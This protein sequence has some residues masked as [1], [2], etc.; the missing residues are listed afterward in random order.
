MH[1]VVIGAG[2]IGV[3]TAY[4][5]SQQGCEVTVVDRECDVASGASFGNGGQLSYSFTDALGKPE[6]I[7]KI[8]AL[9]AGRDRS[10]KMKIAPAL[11][12]WAFRFLSQCTKKRARNNTVAVLKTAMRSATLMN[13][14]RENVPI[15]F[16]HRAAGK[17]VLLSNNEELRSAEVG[18]ELKKEH[19]C[20]AEILQRDATFKIEPSLEK[21]D[22][23]FVAAVYSR[24]DAVAD[25]RLFTE[26]LK[27]WLEREAGVVFR[28][29]ESVSDLNKPN[30]RVSAVQV[31]GEEIA[32]DATV[33]CTGAW[34]DKLLHPLGVATHIYPVRG[35]SVTLPCGAH[36]PS[37]S[38]TAL[39]QRIVFSRL[40]GSMRIAGFADFNG[41]KTDNDARRTEALL[42][43]AQ[44]T[45]PL[46][47]DFAAADPHQWGGFRP[48]TPNGRPHVGASGVD[49]L[50]LN[51]GHGMLGWTLACASGHD[52]AMA[53]M[54]RKH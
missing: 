17:L 14:L 42:D 30:G 9:I 11:V 23:T 50:Y 21:F 6:F 25:A 34:S 15:E 26:G 18:I 8:P 35:Y 27:E 43:V 52:V 51:T 49:G 20:D 24:S 41:F 28:L 54:Q 45:A 5:L 2:V 4:Y 16:S 48:L 37:V 46:A 12:P 22:A 44:Q 33:V 1:V 31:D 40:N 47:A 38:I 13:E 7:S 3:T 39:K 53:V 36:A 32:A 10:S 29:G 19:G